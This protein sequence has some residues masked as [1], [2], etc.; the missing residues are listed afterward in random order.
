MVITDLTMPGMNGTDL[1]EALH[2]VRPEL[3][4][5]MASGFGGL[6][7]AHFARGPG[8]RTVL[9]KPFTTEV[10]ARAVHQ[11]LFEAPHANH[12]EA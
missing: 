6:R 3:P 10:L 4:I 5:I 2:Q 12:P 7:T 9:Q 1:A 8:R 11:L